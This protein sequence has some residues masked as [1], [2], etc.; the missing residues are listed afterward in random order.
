MSDMLKYVYDNVAHEVFDWTVPGPA[1]PK[2]YRNHKER[3]GWTSLHSYRVALKQVLAAYKGMPKQEA[4]D[5][6]KELTGIVD[7]HIG[8]TSTGFQQHFPQAPESP[9]DALWEEWANNC[10]VEM[11]RATTLQRETQKAHDKQSVEISVAGHVLLHLSILLG[12]HSLSVPPLQ[13]VP[14]WHLPW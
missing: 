14:C 10:A 5:W 12:S 6:H 11:N 8:K 7:L 1:R 13:A 9:C 4:G 3:R 2:R